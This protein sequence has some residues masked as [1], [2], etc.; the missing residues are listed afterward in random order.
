MN[1]VKWGTP[2]TVLKKPSTVEL[3]ALQFIEFS[4]F[5]VGDW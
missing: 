4:S 1:K 5:T 2:G 3:G